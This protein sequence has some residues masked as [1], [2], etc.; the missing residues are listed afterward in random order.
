MR[1][2]HFLCFI[3]YFF[4]IFKEYSPLIPTI[5]Y[6]LIL[7]LSRQLHMQDFQFWYLSVKIP[8]WMAARICHHVLLI[9]N[10]QL[11]C[12]LR[13][14]LSV[15]SH[16]LAVL[17][18]DLNPALNCSPLNAP[19]NSELVQISVSSPFFTFWPFGSP[20]RLRTSSFD[21]PILSLE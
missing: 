18:S 7:F 8:K 14:I 20:N 15:I 10:L 1:R 11:P 13:H 21:I 16:Y 19:L 6:I 3:S 9:F 17:K 4:S 2:H 12:A 5:I